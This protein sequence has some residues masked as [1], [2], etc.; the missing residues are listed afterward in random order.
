MKIKYKYVSHCL[1][2]SKVRQGIKPIGSEA[3][4]FLGTGPPGPG[5]PGGAPGKGR[6]VRLH[7]GLPIFMAN[8]NRMFF[9]FQ[10]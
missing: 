3:P 8:F 1:A 2:N 7:P 9:L 10:N 4:G 6:V 5:G